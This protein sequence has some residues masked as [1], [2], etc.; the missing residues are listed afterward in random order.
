LSG[1]RRSACTFYR[2]QE[3]PQSND[4]PDIKP[5]NSDVA[6]SVLQPWVFPA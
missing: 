6:G 2:T 1:M 4:T 3:R 5:S